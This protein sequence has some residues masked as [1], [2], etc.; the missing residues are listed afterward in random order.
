VKSGRV[1]SDVVTSP[2]SPP[3]ERG[4][5]RAV[6]SVTRTK[7]RRFLW[8]AWWSG[9]PC[10]APFRAPDAWSGGARSEEEARTLAE[11][12]AGLPLSP[13]EGRW[14]GAWVRVLAGLPP[15][16]ERIG[17]AAAAASSRPVDPY[18]LLGVPPG[19]PLDEVRAAFRRKALQHHPDLGGDATAFIAVKRAYDR[20]VR[21]RSGRKR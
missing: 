18:A 14:A 5:F 13:I 16:V 6:C 20:I 2:G 3:D 10:A 19:A 15:F 1:S 11:R 21:R 4:L 8:C 9:E 17:G 7:R 12:A